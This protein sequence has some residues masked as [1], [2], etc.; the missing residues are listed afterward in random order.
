MLLL[1]ISN[2]DDTIHPVDLVNLFFILFSTIVWIYWK[3]RVDKVEKRGLGVLLTKVRRRPAEPSRERWR[4][5]G[6]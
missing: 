5:F 4:R 3:N 6:N 1:D 2:V